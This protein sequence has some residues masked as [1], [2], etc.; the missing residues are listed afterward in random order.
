MK[1][2]NFGDCRGARRWRLRDGSNDE[3]EFERISCAV[4]TLNEKRSDVAPEVIDALMNLVTAFQESKAWT[5]EAM[6]EIMLHVNVSDFH[7]LFWFMRA[8]M[9]EN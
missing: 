6:L 1:A 4:E 5:Y 7:C 8:F 2:D 9:S 3:E